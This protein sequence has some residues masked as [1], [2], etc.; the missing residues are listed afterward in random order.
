MILLRLNRAPQ[1]ILARLSRRRIQES[2]SG[3]TDRKD[4]RAWVQLTWDRC[5]TC[6]S[7]SDFASLLLQRTARVGR[8]APQK[9]GNL[10]CL[11][12]LLQHG[13][14]DETASHFTDG[15]ALSPSCHSL[16][17]PVEQARSVD[18]RMARHEPSLPQ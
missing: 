10:Q 14:L 13:R 16:R 8:M 5:Q 12:S 11:I 4:E 17:G 6:D 7:C 18:T 9:T 15:S 3:L 2:V 1:S